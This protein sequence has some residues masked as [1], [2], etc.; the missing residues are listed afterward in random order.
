MIK[1][2]GYFKNLKFYWGSV[3]LN[4]K[5]AQNFLKG[6]LCKNNTVC[7]LLDKF[8]SGYNH[9]ITTLDDNWIAKEFMS[10]AY[11]ATDIEYIENRDNKYD[12]LT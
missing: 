9:Y 3:L 2:N 12:P 4:D 7:I 10:I 6:G 1:A 8:T 5:P 11:H